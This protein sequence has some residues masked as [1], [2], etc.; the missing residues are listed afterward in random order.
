MSRAKS[1]ATPLSLRRV[2]VIP[3]RQNQWIGVVGP[4]PFRSPQRSLR[5]NARTM[6]RQNTTTAF[7]F[8]PIGASGY[9]GKHNAQKS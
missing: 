7:S 6:T 3:E 2:L 1:G 4:A 9:V 8:E 5:F